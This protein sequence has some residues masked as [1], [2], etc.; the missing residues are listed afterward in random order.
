MFSSGR[1][2]IL[3]YVLV[4]MYVTTGKKPEHEKDNYVQNT[5]VYYLSGNKE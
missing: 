1:I 2:L 4:G 3:E 5:V